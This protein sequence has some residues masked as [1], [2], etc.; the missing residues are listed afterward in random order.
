ME[1]FM[2]LSA[3]NAAKSL[4]KQNTQTFE[5]SDKLLQAL[6]SVPEKTSLEL[7]ITLN[8]NGLLVTGFIISQATYFEKLIEGIQSTQ[9]DAE[10]RYSLADFL[11]QLK[12]TLLQQST[13]DDQLQTPHYVHLRNVT[14]Y[15]SEGRGM[16]TFGDVLWRGDIRSING[17]S[18]GEMVPA[19]FD[20]LTKGAG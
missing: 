12:S 11:A 17:F 16:P 3:S 8:V 2:N 6:I 13:A 20:R 10:M 7:G 15:P 1:K 5:R 19:Q 9:A 14:I 4:E 18:L